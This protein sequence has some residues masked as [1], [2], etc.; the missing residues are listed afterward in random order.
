MYACVSCACCTDHRNTFERVSESMRLASSA[1]MVS[2]LGVGAGMVTPSGTSSYKHRS[3]GRKKSARRC[4]AA[5]APASPFAGGA[6]GS[7]ATTM[8]TSSR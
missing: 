2:G 8:S 6:G 7:R 4:A 3:L 5:A 1:A